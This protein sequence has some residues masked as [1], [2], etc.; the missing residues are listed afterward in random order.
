MEVDSRKGIEN[1]TKLLAFLM[2]RGSCA[3]NPAVDDIVLLAQQEGLDDF[4]VTRPDNF[5]I[6]FRHRCTVLVLFKR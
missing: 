3:I 5:L 2:W 4:K 6:D 1:G